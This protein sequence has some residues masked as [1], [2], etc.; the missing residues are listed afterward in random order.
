MKKF[1]HTTWAL[2][3]L[4]IFIGCAKETTEKKY[5]LNK[6]NPTQTGIDFKN[7]L[8]EDAEHSIINYIYF[9][10]GAGVAVGDINNDNLPDLY[11]VSNQGENK[12]YINK[13]NLAFE[14]VS[15]KANINSKSD[16]NTGVTMVDING[17]GHLDIY[18]CSVAGLL[19]Y[20]GHNELFINNG[21]GTFTESAKEY[22]LDFKGYST[23]AY[24]FDFDKD[25]DL[26]VYILNHAVHTTLAHGPAKERNNRMPL[27]G[28]VL[29][30]NNNGK[31]EDV[32]EKAN[33]FGGKNGYGLSATIADF[34]NDGWEDIYVCNDFHEDDYYYINNQDGTFKESL[35]NAFSTTSRFSMGSDSGDINADGFL[36]LITLDMLPKDERVIKESE[37]DDAMFN[38]DKRLDKL[39]YRDQ[40]ARNMLQ[41]NNSGAY[42]QE[43]ALLNKMADSDWSWGPLIADYN[44]DGH[45]DVFIANGILRR[46]NDLDF[47]K[48]VSNTFR[49]YGPEEGVSWLY[50]S[51]NE[52]PSGIVPNQIYKGNSVL[53]EE[54][55]GDW[56]NDKPTLSNGAVYSDLDLDGD[57]DIV[58]NNLNDIAGV[59]ENTSDPDLNH[60]SLKLNFL[61]KNKEGIGSK[62][63]VYCNGRKQYKQLMKSR[64]F[65]SSVDSKLHFGLDTIAKV[66]SIHVIWPNNTLHT[67]SN[68]AVNQELTI[69]YSEESKPYIYERPQ[70]ETPFS[71]E[72]LLTFR[73][74]EDSYNDF[75]NER[76]IPYRVSTLGPA[77]AISDIDNNGFEDVFLGNAS[78]KNAELYLN[79]GNNL[80]RLPI[81]E[82]EKDKIFEDN[83]AVFFDAD[84]DGDQDLYVATGIS[85]LRRKGFEKD[86]LYINNGGNFEKSAD[87]IPD[88][89]LNA[90]VV[91]SN[92]YDGDGDEDLFIG[93]LSN[94][95]SFGGNVA[96]YLLKN[97]GSGVFIKD[98]NFVINS[99]V[100]SAIWKDIDQDGQQDLLV[101]T[102]W[103]A[104]MVFLNQKGNFKQ[105]RIPENLN[106]LWQ[107]ITMFDVDSDGDEDILLGNW[108]KNT[109]FNPYLDNP[110]FM[111]YSDFDSNGK[112]ESVL[113]YNVDGTYYPINSKDELGSQMTEIFD[114]FTNHKDFA[115]QPI[116]KVLTEEAI[117]KAEV[118]EI[119]TLSSGYLVN[120]KGNFDEFIEFPDDFQLAP[121]NSFTNLKLKNENYLLVS[122]NSLSVNTYHGGYTSLKGIL[123]NSVSDY[124]ETSSLGIEPLNK[125]V[126]VSEVVKMK[127]KN[128]LLIGVNNGK[129]KMYSFKE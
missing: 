82:I 2:V 4:M 36:D 123:M 68:P 105:I 30:K 33:I 84:N 27:V 59:Y 120:N 80:T 32:S 7:Q 93:N 76:L 16:W 14:D 18:L 107:S 129:L 52:M 12:L 112:K 79:N 111:Y 115:L 13:G 41:I 24:F 21:D 28:D 110:V 98:E 69:N 99:K 10:N 100:R 15:N 42:F 55:S 67:I 106:G 56:I 17:D 8:Q 102:E 122:G 91:L 43:T 90:S 71:K 61:D 86:R 97:D 62:A 72:E 3:A 103:D 20:E 77:L 64:G 5:L 73:H 92:D 26:D 22:G 74:S 37:G 50:K 25:N 51:I 58:I 121:I 70:K 89:I 85:F 38:I 19:D 117:K 126:N 48:Y 78:G 101:A 87:R 40:Y 57:L 88:N 29:L 6:L 124:K 113:A 108:G 23:Q 109:R 128:L 63:I 46:P 54:K 114:R 47:K 94:P 44:N 125:Q 83:A 31:F 11:F 104:P 1:H 116:E 96:S 39:G 81:P 65:M 60:I 119:N 34:N 49:K 45:Q 66:D 118:F 9:Y 95:R 127:D 35:E 75:L 53:F